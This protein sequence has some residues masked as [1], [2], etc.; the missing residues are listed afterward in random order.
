MSD[1][2]AHFQM[3]ARNSGLIEQIYRR[4]GVTA[5][6][7]SWRGLSELHTARII[8]EGDGEYR[9]ASR[10]RGYLDDFF[11]KNR[12][13]TI[14][15]PLGLSVNA[16]RQEIADLR[17]AVSRGDEVGRARSEGEAIDRIWQL[18]EEIDE[19]VRVFD[20]TTRNGY[21]NARSAEERVRRNAYYHKRAEELLAAI[22]DLRGLELRELMAGPEMRDVRRAFRKQVL[23]R[24]EGWSVRLA[25][26]IKEMLDYLYRS[27]EIADRTKRLRALLHAKRA[28]PRAHR[29]ELLETM[30]RQLAPVPMPLVTRPDLRCDAVAAEANR[31]TDRLRGRPDVAYRYRRRAPAPPPRED[32][33]PEGELTLFEVPV[34]LTR[35][36]DHRAAAEGPVSAREWALS[37]GVPP[38]LLII[39]L[40]DHLVREP[41][42]RGRWRIRPDHDRP[43][44]GQLT[45]IT[46][47]PV[48]CSEPRRDAA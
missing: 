43:W 46:L 34:I 33:A 7:E 14:G 21:H 1:L 38:G 8:I 26:L 5:D 24:L 29:R 30:P 39:H 44:T 11:N 42:E 18:R 4:G 25:G 28:M 16:L 23:D 3:L 20:L 48:R 35:F 36:L 15:T 41:D 2:G 31:I 9:V 10:F 22:Q 27:R 12:S 13:Y 40:Y 17:E 47:D 32:Q 37:E 6:E 45:D 19:E